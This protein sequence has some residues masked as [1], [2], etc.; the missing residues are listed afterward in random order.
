M[1]TKLN[2]GIST[3]DISAVREQLSMLC[4]NYVTMLS[5]KTELS[6]ATVSKF[7]NDQKIKSENG[8][9][10]YDAAL[11]LIQIHADKRQQRALLVNQLVERNI[12]T[13]PLK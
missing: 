3:A 2:P 10:I 5:R 13:P 11:E 7:F 8:E 1:G 4:G 9:R 6:R 12:L